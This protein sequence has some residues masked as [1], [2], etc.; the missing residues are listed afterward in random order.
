[1]NRKIMALLG[2]GML[3]FGSVSAEEAVMEITQTPSAVEV[4]QASLAAEA[5]VASPGM[6]V[7]EKNAIPEK[8]VALSVAELKKKVIKLNRDL[9][10]LEEDLLFPANTQFVVYLSLDTGKFFRPDSVT[11]KLDNQIV[12]AHLYTPRQIKS[13]SRGGMQR[14][15]MGN[16]K[17]G[18]HE[19]TVIVDGLGPDNRAYKRAASLMFDKGSDIASL[20]IKVRDQS[21]N[22]Q[23]HVEIV[24]WN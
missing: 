5:N 12:A 21:E 23:P 11:L 13:L 18:E 16:L 14:L 8:P 6:P 19:L 3:S 24:E 4:S 2:W 17:S 15:H 7:E 1:M 10:I 22:Y 9:F 20:E